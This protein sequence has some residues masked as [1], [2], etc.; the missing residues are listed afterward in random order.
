VTIPFNPIEP[1]SGS[2]MGSEPDIDVEL[3]VHIAL[4]SLCEDHLI[5]TAALPIVLL[6][7][8]NQE[9]LVWQQ[10]LKAM[11]N[12]KGPHFHVGMTLLV[13]YTQYLFNLQHNTARTAMQQRTRLTVYKESAT[14]VTRE[15][16]RLSYEN[17][18]LRNGARPPSEQDR[19]LQEVYRRLSNAEH[20]WNHTRMLL[21]ITREEVDIRTHGIVHLEHH[22]EAQDAEL[23][24]RAEMITNLEQQL[25]EL[26]VQAPPEP[27]NL[28]EIDVMS[29]VDED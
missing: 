8:R 29:G 14:V 18:I 22:V 4:T 2:I 27:A 3:M 25:L 26:R 17:A 16:E 7:I 19:E 5:A 23:E 1:W 28:E 20:E 6:P 11:S 12:L 15:M 24:E 21:N 10:R 13:K 9:N